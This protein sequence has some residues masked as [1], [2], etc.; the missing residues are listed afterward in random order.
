MKCGGEVILG[1]Q[2]GN[3]KEVTARGGGRKR[4]MQV[5]FVQAACWAYCARRIKK[6][7]RYDSCENAIYSL[8]L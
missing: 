3:C 7:A 5:V 1:R 8:G 6:L 2:T 4:D